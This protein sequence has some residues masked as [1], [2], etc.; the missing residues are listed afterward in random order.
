MFSLVF[1]AIC[2]GT[3]VQGMPSL[4]DLATQLNA[5]RLVALL[6]QS[7]LADSLKSGGPYTIIA[8]TDAAFAAI[9]AADMT[10]LN[11]DTAALKNMLEYH[12]IQG[13]IFGWD[14]SMGGRMVQTINGH[15][16]RVSESGNNIYFNNA[17]VLKIEKEATNGV[18]YLIDTV[19]DVPEGTILAVLQK[20]N[21]SM[22]LQAV[23]K[24]RYERMLNH[25]YVG[26]HY[27][28][29]APN[30]VA[31]NKLNKAQLDHILQSSTYAS[32]L[33]RY[34]I[35]SGNLH[36]RS[37]DHNGRISTLYTG[38][39]IGVDINNNDIRLNRVARLSQSDI[40][41]D[42]GVVHIIDHVLIPSTLSGQII[43]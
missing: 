9:P 7:G 15:A 4:V 16:I 28:V 11:S 34:H 14:L 2:F 30:D 8:P 29:F 38:H 23:H 1:A 5:T 18:I 41:C 37:L 33:V 27:T 26:R 6:K 21:A 17:K 12:V 13:E 19:L 36:I 24:I 35:H 39:R 40:E 25:T 10:K 22:F 3:L 20:Y 31:F 43:G 32:E 42:N